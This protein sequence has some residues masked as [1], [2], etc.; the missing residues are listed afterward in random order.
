[1][2]TEFICLHPNYTFQAK[3]TICHPKMK[4]IYTQ[5]FVKNNHE[6]DTEV[7][8]DIL[9]DCENVKEMLS[10]TVP[11]EWERYSLD[12]MVSN[13]FKPYKIIESGDIEEFYIQLEQE[14]GFEEDEV[15][16]EEENE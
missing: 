12:D 10:D 2:S 15:Y 6:K 13:V 4:E 1:M 3:Q 14:L 11:E 8:P 16:S 7:I 9:L 5:K